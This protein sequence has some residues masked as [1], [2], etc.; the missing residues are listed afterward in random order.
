MR[1]CDKLVDV[2]RRQFLRAP[3]SRRRAW[4][5]ASVVPAAG[6]RRRRARRCVAYP[7][8]RL[9]NV[10]D[11]K[12][13]EPLDVAY[14]DD[15]APGVLLKL[16]TKVEAA[17]GP[18]ATSSASRPSAR[19][20]AFRS[21]T[22]RP[23]RRL[24][25]PGHYSRFDCE[26]GGQRDLGPCDPEPAAVHAARRR[27][28]RHLR[29]RA[30]TSSST[31]ACPTCSEGGSDMAYK[32]HID[33]LPII[34]AD[35]KEHNVVC[36]YCI[37]GCGYHAYTWDVN[38]QG[39]TA[40]ADNTFGVD[41]S[42]AAGRRDRRLVLAVDVQHRQ[43]GRPRRSHRH[44]ARQGL[45]RELRP[46]LDPRRAHG[47]DEL[48]PRSGTPQLQRL[49]DPMV[50][51]YGQM[52]PTSWDDALDLV[53]RVTRRG[54]QRAGRG[55]PLRLGLRS[56]RRRRRLREHLGH[57]Q[58]LFRGDEDQEHP[59]PQSPGLQLRGP[60]HPRHGRRRAQQL[61]RGCRARR[62]DLRRRHQCAR[63]PDQLLPEPLGPEPAR[64]LARQEEERAAGRAA[65]PRRGSS[66]SIRAAP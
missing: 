28:G 21:P 51:R 22:T 49:T 38:K 18:T 20:R 25:C 34:P 1:R 13:N 9:G 62:H 24:N 6:A 66:S 4:R 48:Q 17:S 58:A 61:L 2:G 30:S 52:Q 3:A 44:Q 39:G 43:A 5:A 64:H 31:A 42:Q 33:R 27:Q 65:R 60:C 23:T 16:G 47:R 15:D 53:A 35:A 7:S 29:R 41:L 45:R 63:D 55:R 37:V 8:N 57:R 11:L 40:P 46:R 26:K 12:V 36:H 54:D 19:T 59:H 10:K 32:R 50:W 14:P 56:W